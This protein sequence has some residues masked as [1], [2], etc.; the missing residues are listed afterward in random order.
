MALIL[1]EC[2]IKEAYIT[3]FSSTLKEL[4]KNCYFV[5]KHIQNLLFFSVIFSLVF[6]FYYK[7]LK[8]E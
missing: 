5:I 1:Y 2:F 4:E 7:R 3:V 8:Y 6:T